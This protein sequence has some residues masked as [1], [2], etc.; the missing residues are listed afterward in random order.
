MS[1]VVCCSFSF[2]KVFRYTR[3]NNHHWLRSM[4]F[5]FEIALVRESFHFLI[6]TY[7]LG[8][9]RQI[10]SIHSHSFY[11]DTIWEEYRFIQLSRLIF[12][13]RIRFFVTKKNRNDDL[14]MYHC[15]IMLFEKS[16]GMLYFS[17]RLRLLVS[18]IVEFV[19]VQLI[20]RHWNLKES[21]EKSIK[22]AVILIHFFYIDRVVIFRVSVFFQQYISFNVVP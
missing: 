16:E 1:A 3:I 19:D 20:V 5:D 7:E 2:S 17:S 4:S 22:L 8:S 6:R 13:L 10:S 21:C 18:F 14:S 9:W 15:W 11:Y 12:L